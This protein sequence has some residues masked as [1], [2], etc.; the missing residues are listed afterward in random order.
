MDQNSELRTQNYLL[1]NKISPYLSLNMAY[2][3]KYDLFKL[4][5]FFC[6]EITTK[7]K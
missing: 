2:I 7:D 3:N 1:N 6:Q 4:Q 5:G